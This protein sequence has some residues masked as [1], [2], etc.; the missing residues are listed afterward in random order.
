M[1]SVERINLDV[2]IYTAYIFLLFENSR[3]TS[4]EALTSMNCS[5]AE[6]LNRFS[7]IE[8]NKYL[9]VKIVA[10]EFDD[11]CKIITNV[12]SMPINEF[13]L[14]GMKP[15]NKEP[16]FENMLCVLNS[17]IKDYYNRSFTKCGFYAPIFIFITAGPKDKKY[18][19]ALNLLNDNRI[20]KYGAKA[21][22]VVGK[23]DNIERIANIVG[24]K[25]AVIS[26][27]NFEMLDHLRFNWVEVE[28]LVD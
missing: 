21:A 23:L 19:N 7:E 6:F 17:V 22:L 28:S 25:E 11:K 14:F 3:N 1:P 20:Y 2:P 9:T 15:S 12:G 18:L 5:I 27:N 16:D 10:M 4:N 8:N 13:S 24:S 26:K